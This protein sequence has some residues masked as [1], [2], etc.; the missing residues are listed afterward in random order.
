MFDTL[1]GFREAIERRAA[2]IL[3]L[4]VSTCVGLFEL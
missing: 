3:Q 2:D 4:D 1:H